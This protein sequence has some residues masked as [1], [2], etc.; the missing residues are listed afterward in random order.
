MSKND[1]SLKKLT[2]VYKTTTSDEFI[3]YLKPKLQHFVKH[4]FVA[5]WENKQ[6]KHSIKSFPTNKVVSIVDFAKNYTFEVQNEVQSMHW[7]SYQIFI[8]VHIS[9]C[10]NLTQYPYDEDSKTLTKYD[11]YISNDHKHNS[12]FVQHCFKLHWGYMVEQGY[13]P[14]W[15]WVWSDGSASQF[16]SSKP[17]CFVS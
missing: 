6:F 17:R 4:N 12:K 3:D 8:L 16:K 10:H 11:F 1:Q 14:Q 2:L 13:A 5:W 15:H 9:F 7:H